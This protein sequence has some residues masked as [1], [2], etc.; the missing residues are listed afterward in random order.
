MGAV[1]AKE[2]LLVRL[3]V[4]CAGSNKLYAHFIAPSHHKVMEC[5][6][7]GSLYDLLHNSTMVFEGEPFFGQDRLDL[8]IWRMQQNGLNAR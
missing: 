3:F 1:I 5:M 8:L 4:A 7:R 6:S 2:P